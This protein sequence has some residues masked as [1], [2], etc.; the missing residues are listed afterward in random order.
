MA[1]DM[2]SVASAPVEPA[3]A[4]GNEVDLTQLMDM[5]ARTYGMLSRPSPRPRFPAPSR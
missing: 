4:M 5:R 1:E 2:N 3:T